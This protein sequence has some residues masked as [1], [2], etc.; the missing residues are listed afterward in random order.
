MVYI[1]VKSTTNKK[2]NADFNKDYP[3]CRVNSGTSN[4]VQQYYDYIYL[5]K[6]INIIEYAQIIYY[7]AVITSANS[8]GLYNKHVGNI[9]IEDEYEE[10]C[11]KNAFNFK[12]KGNLTMDEFLTFCNT[13]NK[14]F[15]NSTNLEVI[16]KLNIL[17]KNLYMDYS[18]GSYQYRSPAEAEEKYILDLLKLDIEI[19]KDI[20]TNNILKYIHKGLFHDFKSDLFSPLLSKSHLTE[21]TSK[22]DILYNVASEINMMKHASQTMEK[23]KS[24]IKTQVDDINR[25]NDQLKNLNEKLESYQTKI[26]V[27][28]SK[29]KKCKEEIEELKK[30]NANL[31]NKNESLR[32]VAYKAEDKAASLE[33]KYKKLNSDYLKLESSITTYQR[34][35]TKVEDITCDD[36]LTNIEKISKLEIRLKKL[37]LAINKKGNKNDVKIKL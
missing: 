19:I 26:A 28:D 36:C 12:I 21:I 29:I 8:P 2:I 13:R 35:P 4:G 34:N 14:N 18:S 31:D 7:P 5:H 32:K 17:I 15:A 27:K 22:I 10:P 37:E 11:I 23:F 30:E 6:I 16:I 1:V 20:T 3:Q 24:T 25:L 33:S 9:L